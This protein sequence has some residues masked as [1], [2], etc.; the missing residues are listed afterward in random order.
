MRFEQVE[1]VEQVKS[2]YY[3]YIFYLYSR[4]ILIYIKI[5]KNFAFNRNILLKGFVKPF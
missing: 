3:I 5:Y 2:L 1:Q 4:Y